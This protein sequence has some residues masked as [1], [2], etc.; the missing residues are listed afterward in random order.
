[1]TKADLAVVG[2][3]HAGVE[4]AAAAARMGCRVVLVTLSKETIGQMPC[5]PAIGGIGK[6]HL[7]SEIDAL[8]GVQGWA[9][10]RAGIQFRLLNASRGPAVWGPRAQCDKFFYV[11]LMRRLM[12][13]LPRI[14]II[15]DEAVG[16]E[17]RGREICGLRLRGGDR[18]DCRAVILTTGTFLDAVLHCGEERWEGGRLGEAPSLGL[19]GDLRRLGLELQRFKTGTPP[20]IH[21]R[22][23]DFEKLEEQAGDPEPR[24]FSWRSRRVRNRTVCWIARTPPRVQEIISSNLE[25]SPLFSGK[26]E[27]VGPRY[28]PSIEDKVVRFP[29]HEEHTIFVEPENLDGPSIYLNGVSTSLPKDVQEAIVRAMP[30][31]ERAEFLRYGYAVEY[32]IVRPGQVGADLGVLGL[33]GLYLAG[34][35]LGTSGYEEAAALGLMAGINAA[36][37]LKG[38]GLFKLGREEAYIGVLIDDLISREHR[39]PYRMFTSR[40]EHR[41]LLGVDSARE[42]LMPAG[43]SLGLV[44][45]KMFHVEHRRILRRREM[46]EELEST[47]INPTRENREKVRRILGVDFGS[48]TSLGGL[49]RRNDIR[50]EGL[51]EFFPELAELSPDERRMLLGRLRYSGYL[52][53]HRREQ[54]RLERLRSVKLPSNLDYRGIPGLSLEVVETLELRRP[55]TLEEAARLGGLTPAALA[56]IAGRLSA[57]GGN[58][59]RG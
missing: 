6:G 55:E 11:D 16:L 29:H 20:R 35:I 13:G 52:E 40:A 26:I 36:R 8:G 41:L 31:F 1:M 28:C 34:Q 53:R 12:E 48:P 39:E 17:R 22:S 43:V 9:A 14:E 4:A 46:L 58:E 21:R 56:L 54:R 10:D 24:P 30:G 32:D 45:E 15:E 25:R 3:G 33:E 7:V 37:R 51:E 59:S 19:G 50:P 57:G 38:E 49:F 5:N 44:P 18:V 2:G 42:R 27:G 47:P 23:I